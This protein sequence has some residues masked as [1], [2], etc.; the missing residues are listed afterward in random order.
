M[1][2]GQQ[3]RQ[4]R[5]I[6]VDELARLIDAGEVRV[7]E[8]GRDADASTSLQGHIPGAVHADWKALLWH[9]TDRQLADRATLERRLARLGVDERTPV[10]IYGD[11][12][13]YGTYA[14]WVLACA[15]L[16]D[17]VRMLDGTARTWAAHGHA[18]E[19]AGATAPDLDIEDATTPAV[20][21][22]SVC[23][24][25]R[26]DMLAALDR[27]DVQ[28]LDV[29]SPEEYSGQRV[30]P[31][32]FEVDHGAQRAGRIPGAIHL[33]YEDLLRED[34]SFRDRDE[35]AR[36]VGDAGLDPAAEILT[37]CR[38]SHRATLVWFALTEL[39]G[40][41]SVRVYDGSWTEWGSMVGMPI[42]R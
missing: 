42:E 15:G 35:L 16:V 32:T 31:A 5:L 22:P 17:A 28:I 39:L 14:Y 10:V 41:E 36:L 3:P 6:G 40:F 4:S 25:G 38:L 9:A 8:V 20:G 30:S 37:Y 34:D 12:V 11:P 21:P 33:H 23:R 13:Q 1:E 29:R 27:A 26:D 2:N 7:I 24:A 19:S 18:L